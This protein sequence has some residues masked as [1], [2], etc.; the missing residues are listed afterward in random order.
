MLAE[1]VLKI[2]VFGGKTVSLRHQANPEKYYVE[3]T[4]RDTKIMILNLKRKIV[5]QNVLRFYGITYHDNELCFVNDYAGKGNLKD[6]LY[7]SN[8]KLDVNFKFAIA[9][10]VASGMEFLQAQVANHTKTQESQRYTCSLLHRVRTAHFHTQFCPRT[11]CH[12]RTC[13]VKILCT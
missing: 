12:I 2:G 8:F 10:D 11:S 13:N 5:H 6:V 3:V 7:D 9:I 4:K 1:N